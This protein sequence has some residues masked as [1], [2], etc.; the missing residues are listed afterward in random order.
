MR[1]SC[2]VSY[3]RLA[4]TTSD[5]ATSFFTISRPAGFMGL[6]VRPSLLRPIWRNIAPSPPS[7]TGVT[8]RSSL[9]SSFS[10]RITSAPR[11]PS[12]VPQNGPA[13]YRPKSRTRIPSRTP[14]MDSASLRPPQA[15]RLR[16]T[17]SR[18][19]GRVGTP[20][21][22]RSI[23][24]SIGLEEERQHQAAFVGPGIVPA[25]GA[26]PDVVARP[27]DAVMVGKGAFEHEGL[28]DGDMLVIG[29]LGAGRPAHQHGR[30]AGRLVLHQDLAVDPGKARRLPGYRGDIDVRRI[31]NEGLGVHAAALCPAAFCLAALSVPPRMTWPGRGRPTTSSASLATSIRRS[32][33]RPV[34]TPISSHRKAKS[35]VQMLPAAPSVAANGQ[36]PM[37]AIEPSYF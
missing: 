30:H 11:S 22:R 28:L 32:M 16:R 35:S 33:S 25:A 34:S 7:T 17:L 15:E 31:G 37:P 14:D 20:Q 18:A 10:M 26:A 29:Q 12:I 4:I 1:I 19:T 3:G 9:P 8:Q 2:R 6:S 13:M 36:P 21:V 5:W 23:E 24:E 27:A